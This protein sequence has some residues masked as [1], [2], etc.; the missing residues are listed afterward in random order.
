M[1]HLDN[2]SAEL[3]SERGSLAIG[4]QGPQTREILAKCNNS[5]DEA[6]SSKALCL[7]GKGSSCKSLSASLAERE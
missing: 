4:H 1:V 2:Y 5:T 3:C 7:A 6:T